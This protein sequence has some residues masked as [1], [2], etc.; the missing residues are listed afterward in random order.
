MSQ[1]SLYYISGLL[2][3]I[4]E[5]AVVTNPLVNSYKRLIPGY[6]APV[7]IAWSPSNRSALI[8]VPAKRGKSTRIELRSPDPSCNPY[9]AFAVMLTA[10]LKGIEDKIA[11]PAPT[12]VN[13]YD[14]NEAERLEHSIPSLPGSLYEALEE[15]NI[16]GSAFKNL[17]LDFEVMAFCFERICICHQLLRRKL[18]AVPDL[19]GLE[20]AYLLAS[21]IWVSFEWTRLSK[22]RI[23]F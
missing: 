17:G 8:R 1:K 9:L 21:K 2:K 15:F 10:G 12:Q 5:F 13:I 16:V 23:F 18:D 3:Y 22:Y 7:Y 11:P 19:L 20:H 4:R 14:M 6:E